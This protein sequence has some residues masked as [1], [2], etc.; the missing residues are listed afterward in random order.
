M[1]ASF[2]W[3]RV[4]QHHSYA[5]GGHGLAEYFGPPDVLGA[6]VDGRACESCN[7]TTC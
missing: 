6:R 3:D 1:A 4:T 2:F 7:T 5:T